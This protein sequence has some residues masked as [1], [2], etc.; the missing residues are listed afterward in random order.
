MNATEDVV[1]ETDS[2]IIELT[3]IL[4][5]IPIEN[6]KFFLKKHFKYQSSLL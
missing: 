5:L 2:I 6:T 3:H 4:T 1:M